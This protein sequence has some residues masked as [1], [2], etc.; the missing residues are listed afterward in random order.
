M[1]SV[2]KPSQANVTTFLASQLG[3]ALSYPD[4]GCS[5][6]DLL[7][8]Y[9]VDHYRQRL[10]E[11]QQTFN[12]ACAALRHWRMLQLDWVQLC[13]STT[14]IEPGAMVAVLAHWGGLWWLNACRIVYIVDEM[15][16][17]RRFGFAYS[18][19][20]AHVERGEERFMVEW[21]KDN[22]VWYDLLACSKPNRWFA[23]L[24]YPYVRRLQKRFAADSLTAMA[25]AVRPVN[26]FCE[27]GDMS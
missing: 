6:Q 19:L 10:G 4:V 11:G 2:R 17:T 5:R 7:S 26:R 22:S 3:L 27:T 8:G 23:R 24:G 21:R 1:L 15:L 20:P 13:C 12:V 9:V 25:A 18:T 14:P 16:P